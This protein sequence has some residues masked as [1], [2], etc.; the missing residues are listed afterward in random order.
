M[1]RIGQRRFVGTVLFPSPVAVF[2]QANLQ[3]DA[4]ASP[5]IL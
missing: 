4:T 1:R 2:A 5:L 3:V